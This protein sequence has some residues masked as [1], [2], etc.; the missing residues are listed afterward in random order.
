MA[1]ASFYR[2]TGVFVLLLALTAASYWLSTHTQGR[3]LALLVLL[4]V[5]TKT[6]LVASDF[7][8]LRRVARVWQWPMGIYL[9]ALTA[10]L[11][12]AAT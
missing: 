12:L 1:S 6:A 8:G 4:I 9:L 11:S 10:L 7:M 3:S 2:N 5:F